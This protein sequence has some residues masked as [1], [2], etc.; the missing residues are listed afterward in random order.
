MSWYTLAPCCTNDKRQ[1]KNLSR[2]RP[3]FKVIVFREPLPIF[4]LF[5]GGRDLLS[6]HHESEDFRDQ[7]SSNLNIFSKRERTSCVWTRPLS[8]LLL[9]PPRLEPQFRFSS[10]CSSR[11]NSNSNSQTPKYNHDKHLPTLQIQ[12]H[13]FKLANEPLWSR[14]STF[15]YDLYHKDDTKSSWAPPHSTSLDFVVNYVIISL[16]IVA[17]FYYKSQFD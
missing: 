11:R 3:L 5:S 7:F 6:L 17:F 4:Q 10:N 9:L 15:F 2:I 1:R 14:T 8:S 12:D 13:H 16:R